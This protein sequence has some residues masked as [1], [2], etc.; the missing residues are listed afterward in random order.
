MTML[1]HPDLFPSCHKNWASNTG[2]PTEQGA[3]PFRLGCQC[4]PGGGSGLPAS[5]PLP[6]PLHP[7]LPGG[8]GKVNSLQGR[9]PKGRATIQT[10]Q[11]PSHSLTLPGEGW[12]SP[13]P[14]HHGAGAQGSHHHWLPGQCPLPSPRRPILRVMLRAGP[15]LSQVLPA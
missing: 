15:C 14:C 2:I 5:S 3:P 11:P 9:A 13:P 8:K 6:I 12:V 7:R 4:L 10:S 1:L